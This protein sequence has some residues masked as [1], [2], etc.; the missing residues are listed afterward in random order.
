[1]LAGLIAAF[2]AQGME[3]YEAARLG[4]YLHGLAGALAAADLGVHGVVAGD[5]VERLPKAFL[6]HAAAGGASA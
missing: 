5:M 3:A 2:L 6:A 1:M 4:A